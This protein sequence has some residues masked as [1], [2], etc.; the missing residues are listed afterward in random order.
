M[1]DKVYVFTN[2]ISRK[3]GG[4]SSILDLANNIT[5]LGLKVEMNSSLGFM[6]RYIY[7]PTNVKEMINIKVLD[8]N[9]YL[10]KKPSRIKKLLNKILNLSNIFKDN[11]IKESIVIDAIGL[12]SEFIEKLKSNKCKVIYNHAGSPNAVMKYFGLEGG[13]RDDL[14]KAKH[15]YLNMI[16]LY[17]NILFQSPTQAEKLYELADW[18]ID[19]TLVLRPSASMDDINKVIGKESILDKDYFD[20][21]VVGSVQERKGQHLLSKISEI[22]LKEVNNIRFHIVGNILD[23]DYKDKVEKEIQK[24]GLSDKIIFHGFKSNYLEY[25]NSADVILQV[26]EEEGVSRILREAMALK[27]VII[28]FSL[29]G[30]N[31]LLENG[32]D[33]LLSDYGDIENI[34]HD[35]LKVYKDKELSKIL[36]LKAFENF[37]VKYSKKEYLRQLR[38]LI[39]EVSSSS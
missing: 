14:E 12:P 1:N 37:K 18:E 9:I 8:H 24:K 28:S 33:C 13:K 31:D 22:L 39:D 11:E 3:N 21:V 2:A 17:S 16:N 4:S 7:K 34:A 38:A 5:E 25:M 6:D 30:T 32:E 29:D 19:R 20:I 35:I 15:D 23:Q 10:S 26:S 27:K 36:A